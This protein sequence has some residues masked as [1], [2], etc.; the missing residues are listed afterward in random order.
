MGTLEVMTDQGV[1]SAAL[2]RGR[3]GRRDPS[4]ISPEREASGL[5]AEG[6]MP[7]LPTLCRVYQ[8]CADSANLPQL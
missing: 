4:I 5:G 6:R 7:A 2:G 3:L 8:P 1:G